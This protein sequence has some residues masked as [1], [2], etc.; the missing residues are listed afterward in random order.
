MLIFISSILACILVLV[1]V[2]LAFSPGTPKPFLDDH[3]RPLAGSIS[4][5]VFVDINGVEQ[6]MFIKGRDASNPVLL[7]LHGGLPDYFMTQKYPTGLEDIF[8]VVWWEQRGSGLSFNADISLATITTE[9]LISD[10]LAVTD[11]LRNRFHQDK[12]YLMGHSGGSF[13]GIQAAARAPQLYMAYIGMSQMS[14]Q[15]ESEILAYDYMLG[16]YR[17]NGNIKMVQRLEAAPVTRTGGTPVAYL[18]IRDQAM[19]G[20]GIGTT[21]T[22]DS[23]VT[24][25]FLPSLFFPEYTLMEKLALWRGKARSGVSPLWTEMISTN[26]ARTVTTLEVFVYFFHGSYD[27]TC[28]SLLA[29]SY[30]GS[31]QAPIKGFYTFERSAHSPMFEEPGKVQDI[32]L[33]DVLAGTNNLADDR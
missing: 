23:V 33:K 13:F 18:A 26:L 28:S 14:D 29:K 19:H 10:T 4:E 8:T 31:L 7:Y 2:L 15:L 25:I 17:A 30:L 22:M 12:I 6:G 32:L 20:L 11:Y 27:Y 1:V 9:Q 16:Q 21:H 24:G 3:D 5:K